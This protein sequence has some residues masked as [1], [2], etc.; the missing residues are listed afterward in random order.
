MSCLA[1]VDYGAQQAGTTAVAFL[2]LNT[3]QVSFAQSVKKKSADEWLLKLLCQEKPHLIALDAPLSLPGYYQKLPDFQ[4]YFY[5]ESDRE[6][7]AMSPLFLGGLTARAIRLRDQL[8]MQNM[9]VFETYPA[10]IAEELGLKELSY[11]KQQ[12]H[13]PKVARALLE[14]LPDFHIPV[15]QIT[16][17]HRLDALL[18]LRTAWR[19]FRNEATFVGHEREGGI[20]I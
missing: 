7:R 17:W 2:D 5:R 3:R 19:K 18:A 9:E 16:N 15:D 13:I 11:K 20:F 1:G 8:E 4:D 12:E 10:Q 14:Y 6:L